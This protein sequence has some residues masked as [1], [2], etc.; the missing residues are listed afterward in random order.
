[1][2]EPIT[3]DDV[4]FL[5]GLALVQQ[6]EARA[7]LHRVIAKIAVQHLS[8][9]ERDLVLYAVA[10]HVPG[11]PPPDIRTHTFGG[12]RVSEPRWPEE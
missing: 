12:V 10:D 7:A 1:M 8:G 9:H 6:P 5:M 4:A 3:Y 2:D 11:D